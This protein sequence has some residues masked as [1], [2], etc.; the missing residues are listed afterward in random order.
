M[1][2]QLAPATYQAQPLHEPNHPQPKQQ[3]LVRTTLLTPEI[4]E[5]VQR[6]TVQQVSYQPQITGA[7]FEAV[8]PYERMFHLGSDRYVQVKIFNNRLYVGIRQFYRDHTTNKMVATRTGINLIQPEWEQFA[9]VFPQVTQSV[10]DIIA[11]YNAGVPAST[12]AP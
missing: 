11:Q 2:S 9:A 7:A 4:P 12:S 6:N 8:R 3:R 10:N 1:S 5:V